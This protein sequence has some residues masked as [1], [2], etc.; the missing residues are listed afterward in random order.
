MYIPRTKIR[1]LTKN[2]LSSQMQPRF[3]WQ[4][5]LPNF[6]LTWA[7]L[8]VL[9]LAMFLPRRWTMATGK[10]IG[11]LLYARNHKRRRIA[12]I[13]I[14]LCF[15]ELDDAERAGL[16]RRHFQQYARGLLDAGYAMWASKARRD[17]TAKLENRNWLAEISRQHRVIIVGYHMTTLE[18]S[19]LLL[20]D[21]HPCVTM[22]QRA[23]NPLINWQLWKGRAHLDPKN[24]KVVLREQGIRAV[25]RAMQAGHNCYFVADEDF[26]GKQHCV[27]APFFGVPTATL[28]VISRLAKLTNAIVVPSITRLDAATGQ[29][30]MV[31]GAPLNNFPSMNIV[32]DASAV[33][34]AMEHL[35]RP[36]PEIYMW[37][38]RW[39]KTQP[40]GAPNPYKK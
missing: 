37:T 20:S 39:F 34:L 16:I 36:T 19:G 25:I 35:I 32:A 18:I 22:M 10:I 15:P 3:L 2:R 7:K 1:R 9:Y 40:N 30:K 14:Q 6:W 5:L 33:N 38:F 28:T 29:Y 13:N 4:F 26:G 11:N 24:I 27:F 12:E 21:V 8:L 17:A 31:F 23:R